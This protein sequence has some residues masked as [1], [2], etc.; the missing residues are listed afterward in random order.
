MK[1]VIFLVVIMI[2][3][4]F[5]SGC[6]RRDDMDDI[7]II[8]TSYPITY[9]ANKIYGSNSTVQSIYPNAIDIEDYELTDKQIKEYAKS[10]LFIYNGLNPNEKRIAT[11][12]LNANK[13]IKLIDA[14]QGLTLNTSYE[15]LWLSPSNFLMSAQNIREH[16]E[17][18]IT[19]TVIKNELN[20]NYENIKLTISKYDANFKI[21]AE[22]A[23]YKDVIVAN[24]SLKFLSKYGFNVICVDEKEDRYKSNML[25]AKDKISAKETNV[26]FAI[27]GE[28]TDSVKALSKTV[29]NVRSMNN[30]T[31]EEVKDKT[32]YETMM[33]DFIESLRT[34][35]YSQ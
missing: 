2:S 29:I 5:M 19:S 14:T 25:T 34:E 27:N 9:L 30:L 35:A 26:V 10:D 24:Q 23:S 17:N 20:K 7:N 6:I 3:T 8:T 33:N 31:V 4:L 21:I 13:N 28:V 22:N 1:K 16:L 11:R 12:L 15:E 18:Y 32:T